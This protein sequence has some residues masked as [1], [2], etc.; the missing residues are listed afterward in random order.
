[1]ASARAP[2]VALRTDI[3]KEERV[4]FTAEFSGYNEYEAIGRYASLWCWCTDRGLEDAP[5]DCEGY[6]VPDAVVRR[7]LGARGVEAILGDGC[8]ELAMGERR[9]DGLIYLRGTSDTVDRLRS[10][11]TSAKAG[12]RARHESGQRSAGRF[13]STPTVD[14]P[15]AGAAGDVES[16]ASSQTV[17]PASS[18]S[19]RDPRSQ[20]PDPEDQNSPSACAIPSAVPQSEPAPTPAVSLP[21]LARE[22]IARTQLE[23]KYAREPV[24]N[25]S[26]GKPAYDLVVSQATRNTPENILGGAPVADRDPKPENVIPPAFDPADPRAIGRLAEAFYRRISDARI[27]IA[28]EL[29][30]PEP[31]PFPAIT[32][33]TNR[34]GFADLRDRIREEGALAPAACERVIANLI[35]Q[36]RAKKSID[37]LGE[38]AF[39]DKAWPN[40]RDGIDPSARPPVPRRGDPLPPAPPP[41]RPDPPPPDPVLSPEDRAAI[42]ELAARVGANPEAA[43]AELVKRFGDARAGPEIAAPTDHDPDQPRRKAA[44]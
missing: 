2:F 17:Q 36:A 5:E 38:R 26:F 39:G 29:K 9:P 12:G 1:V 22:D 28:V 4:R 13:V 27:A 41:K 18:R 11:R 35:T 10:L 40:A 33:G 25:S 19:Q 8:D 6:A 31:L 42:A 32:P 44:K 21:A 20:I 34:R 16:S 24:T 43:A 14:Q 30:L 15:P 7:F 23:P 37:W 3:R